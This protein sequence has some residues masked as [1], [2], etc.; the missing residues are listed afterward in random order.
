YLNEAVYPFYILH[1]T[2]IVVLCYVIVQAPHESILSKYSFTVGVTFFI[3]M[4]IYHL[5]IRPFALTRF[6]F[7]MK[8]RRLQPRPA[9]GAGEKSIPDLIIPA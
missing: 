7:G 6:L 9:A 8:P 3:S 4:G 2:V 1:Q 5:F